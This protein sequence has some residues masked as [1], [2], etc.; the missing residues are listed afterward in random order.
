MCTFNPYAYKALGIDRNQWLRAY[1]ANLDYLRDCGVDAF[2]LDIKAHDTDK[3]KWLTGCSNEAILKLPEEIL[4]RD[5][6]LEVLSLYIPGL[7]EADELESIAR[8]L[9]EVDR[10]IP[11]TILAFFPEYRMKEFARPDVRE[12]IEAYDRVKATG[13]EK[14][15]LGNVGVFAPTQEDQE[16]LMSCVEKG[17]Y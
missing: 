12:M 15:R 9:K 3:H 13:L 1:P 2:W 16:Y 7:V 17:V 11:F 10:S 6:V 4:K 5:F 8:S 14:I